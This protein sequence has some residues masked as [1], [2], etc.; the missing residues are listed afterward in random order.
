MATTTHELIVATYAEEEEAR[1]DYEAVRFTYDHDGINDTF[2]VAVLSR[3]T[4]GKVHIVTR[5]DEP[6]RQGAV[7]GLVTGL[8]VGVLVGLAPGT[9][10]GPSL[11]IAGIAGTAIGAIAGHVARG[12]SRTDL[13]DL[14]YL[15]DSGESGLVVVADPGLARRAAWAITRAKDIVRRQ[16]Q[17]DENL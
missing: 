5:E 3:D 1:A 13:R 6:T 10:I 15:L 12:L 16:V 2:D 14:G 4:K 9:A 17:R 8:S 7:G 11:A